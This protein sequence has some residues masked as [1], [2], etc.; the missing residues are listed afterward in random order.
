MFFIAVNCN[1]LIR[2]YFYYYTGRVYLF[3]FL[4]LS[5]P[6]ILFP[7]SL[8]ISVFIPIVSPFHLPGPVIRAEVGDTI[9]VIFYNRASQPFSIQ[10]HGV[11]Y[12]KDYEGTVYNNGEQAGFPT[13]VGCSKYQVALEG[14]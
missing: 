3:H 5:L 4:F 7:S 11:F 1:T 8:V 10:P 14:K 6:L 13:D 9:Q 2:D 12:E